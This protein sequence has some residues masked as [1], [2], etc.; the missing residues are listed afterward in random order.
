M[1]KRGMSASWMA[2]I[3]AMRKSGKGVRKSRKFKK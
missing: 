3:R 1:G 2:K